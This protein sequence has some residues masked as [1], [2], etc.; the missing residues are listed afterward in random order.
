VVV[1]SATSR[2]QTL[3]MSASLAAELSSITATVGALRDRVAGLTGPLGAGTEDLASALYEVE[4]SLR[5]A[6]R[7]LDRAQRL[8]P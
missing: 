1:P 3:A 5:N 8:L 7:H 4:R 2:G 6:G